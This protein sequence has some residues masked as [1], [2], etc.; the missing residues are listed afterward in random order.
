MTAND[1]WLENWQNDPYAKQWLD[2]IV[3]PRTRKNYVQNFIKWLRFIGMSPTDQIQK[4][5]K[6][7][8]SDNPKTRGFFEDKLV[9]FK[10][11][12]V[13]QNYKSKSVAT[14]YTPTLSFF[15]AHR[16]QLRFKRGELKVRERMVDK[17]VK[18]WIP[19]NQQVKQIYQ[20]GSIRDRSLLLCLFQSG[21]S[22]T[23]VSSLNIED[24]PDLL[25]SEGHYPI[26]L[27]RAKTNVLQRTCISEEC[28]HDLK[29]MLAERKNPTKGALFVSQKHQRLSVRFINEAIKRMVLDTYGEDQAKKWK[30]KSLRDAYNDALLRANLTQEIKDTLFGHRRQ[31]AK[32][33]YAVSQTTII[34]AYNKAFQFLSVNHGTQAR[35][36]I[37][38]MSQQVVEM[39]ENHD[40]TIQNLNELLEQQRIRMEQSQKRMEKME[41]KLNSIGIDPNTLTKVLS[42]L[43]T[44]TF[45]IKNIRKDQRDMNIYILEIQD[46]VKIKPKPIKDYA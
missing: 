32:E 18:E 4:R 9:E 28:I 31:G 23:D 42:N 17:V 30:T 13:A 25:T 24:L 26:V 10:N 46:K 20:H 43:E 36:D 2:K 33:R 8:R 14:H 22:E 45:E 41:N 1:D 35:K 34:D 21:F 19:E 6:D 44:I 37:E 11:A 7:L 40:R 38:V 5:F 15:S 27:H 12:S 16:V 3:S 39:N 29:A